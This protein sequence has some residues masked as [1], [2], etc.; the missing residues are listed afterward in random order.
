MG[1]KKYKI[2]CPK[3]LTSLWKH[4]WNLKPERAQICVKATNSVFYF[5]ISFDSISLQFLGIN[6]TPSLT[7][8]KN[9]AHLPPPTR[10]ITKTPNIISWHGLILCMASSNLFT[11]KMINCS[12]HFS[13]LFT[14]QQFLLFESISSLKVTFIA[15]PNQY[16]LWSATKYV[17]DEISKRTSHDSSGHL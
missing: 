6:F 8:T 12:F 7:V 9:Y 4:P 10:M 15:F 2:K 14:I 11:V 13:S 5:F 3:C 17:W 16:A 1:M